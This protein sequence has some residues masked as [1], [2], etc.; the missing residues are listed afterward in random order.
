VSTSA[1]GSRGAALGEE[2]RL[3]RASI[4]DSAPPRSANIPLVAALGTLAVHVGLAFAASSLPSPAL[5]QVVRS[6]QISEMVEVEI[7]PPPEPEPEPEPEAEPKPEPPVVAKP[8]EPKPAAPKPPAPEA[9]AAPPPA[10]AQA[11]AVLDAPADIVDFG[12][13]L[14]TGQSASYAGGVT[15]SNGTATRAV[16]DVRAQAGGVIGGT[17]TDPNADRSRSPRLTGGDVWNCPFPPEADDFG[18]DLAVVSLSVEV[19]ASGRVLDASA[20]S[21]PGHGFAREARR[22]ALSKRWDPGLDRAGNP[23]RAIARVNVKFK[24]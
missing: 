19:D 17:G 9:T 4:L 14:V 12:D 23:M 16:R 15:A 2:A 1:V 5:E 11:G 21:D 18:V 3:A 20:K 8:A 7:P 22:C 10:A 6:L 24:R 13:T